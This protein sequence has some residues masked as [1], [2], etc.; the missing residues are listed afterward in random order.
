M[1]S[2]TANQHG[3]HNWSITIHVLGEFAQATTIQHP[4]R[5][6]EQSQ[7]DSQNLPKL[8][9]TGQIVPC[10]CMI[11]TVAVPGT[12]LS[13]GRDDIMVNGQF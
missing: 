2:V 5:I 12:S 1:Q 11:A 10:V 7:S 6:L 4:R 8:L 3:G 13:F 9:E